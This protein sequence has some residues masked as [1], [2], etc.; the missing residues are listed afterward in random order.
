MVEYGPNIEAQIAERLRLHSSVTVDDIAGLSAE[1]AAPL[2]QRYAQ[3]HGADRSMSFDG[4][5]LTLTERPDATP[6]SGPADWGPVPLGAAIPSPVDQVLASGGGRSALDTRRSE[7]V[8]KA[9]WLLPV[10]LG[11][12]GGVVAWFVTRDESPRTARS[13]LVTGVVVQV[14]TMVLPLLMLPSLAPVMSMLGGGGSATWPAS[15]EGRP[16]LYYFGTS[17]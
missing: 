1:Q 2:L 6:G 16:T 5:T 13:L 8:S 10:A 3:I 4:R 11:L 7:S 15:S 17:T 14:V 9:M 12:L